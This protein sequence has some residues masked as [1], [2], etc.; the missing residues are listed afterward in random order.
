M[1]N[2]QCLQ[3]GR[4]L[5]RTVFSVSNITWSDNK[6]RSQKFLVAKLGTGHREHWKLGWNSYD[7]T[8]EP[9]L[10]WSIYEISFIRFGQDLMGGCKDLM[11]PRVQSSWHM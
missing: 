2:A 7:V 1:A 11:R 4:S 5:S 10:S 8:L 6:I 9:N 3:G